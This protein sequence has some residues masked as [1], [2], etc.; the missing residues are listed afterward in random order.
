RLR[1]NIAWHQGR[2]LRLFVDR[3]LYRAL[4]F[5]SFSRYCRERAG[6]GVRRA[7]DLVTLERR[8]WLLPRVADAYRSG[9]VSW[10]RAAAVARVAT[11]R[12][13]ASW[14]RLALSITVRRL[15]EEVALAQQAAV[16]PV[17]GTRPTFIP[18]A[19]PGL[20]ADGRVQL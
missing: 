16:A 1:Q 6:L 8:L 11:E 15:N 12:T 20:E 10:V 9:A 19:Q 18:S 2:L 7:W 13:E 5:M 4:G 3:R 17:D 14:L